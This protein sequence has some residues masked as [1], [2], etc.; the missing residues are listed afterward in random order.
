MTS[1]RFGCNSSK[2]S[3]WV[4]APENPG[5][6]ATQSPV[7]GQRSTTA[8]KVRMEAVY[9]PSTSLRSRLRSRLPRLPGRRANDR[10]QREKHDETLRLLGRGRAHPSLGTR[11][12]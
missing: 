3:A 12:E 6:W 11:G 1:L 5:T 8:G 7:S 4:C 2:V 10:Q 9:V